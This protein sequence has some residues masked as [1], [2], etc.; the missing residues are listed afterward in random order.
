MPGC[1]FK[2]FFVLAIACFLS[3]FWQTSL[4]AQPWKH[5][6]PDPNQQPSGA[7]RD[8]LKIK[9]P[10]PKSYPSDPLDSDIDSEM[11]KR[12][13][14][15]SFVPEFVALTKDEVL[16]RK[17]N[18]TREQDLMRKMLVKSMPGEIQNLDFRMPGM[19]RYLG[20]KASKKLQLWLWQVSHC[21]VLQKWKDLGVRYWPRHINVGRCSRKATC[22]FPSGMRCRISKTKTVGV[23]R[24]HCLDRLAER[25]DTTCMWL[26]FLYP[27]I[28]QCKCSCI[29]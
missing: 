11:L 7:A 16:A 10:E 25:K 9:I 21:S 6:K 5:L 26:K 3:T 19:K 1:S 12:K 27:I 4:E 29:Q 2:S 18:D 20:S 8:K 17:N 28:T 15:R 14:N 13:L 23:L 24:W 22:S